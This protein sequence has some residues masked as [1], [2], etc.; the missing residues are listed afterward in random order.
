MWYCCVTQ[1]IP[2][3]YHGTPL[4]Y[5]GD[6]RVILRLLGYPEMNKII[7]LSGLLGCMVSHL[8]PTDGGSISTKI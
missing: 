4:L 7:S 5:L 1:V 3:S 6:I 2:V 8:D